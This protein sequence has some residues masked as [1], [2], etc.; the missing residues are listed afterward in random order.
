[1]S[2]SLVSAPLTGPGRADCARL[3]APSSSRRQ[4]RWPATR[5]SPWRS[6]GKG[7]GHSAPKKLAADLYLAL[8]IPVFGIQLQG[9]LDGHLQKA[10]AATSHSN[11]ARGRG[12]AS[13]TWR[14]LTR[15]RGIM[16]RPSLPYQLRN[17]FV[18]APTLEA[19]PT[20]ETAAKSPQFAV[21]RSH[22]RSIQSRTDSARAVCAQMET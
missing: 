7:T 21:S 11:L 3:L 1:M 9:H 2:S 5:A 12:L 6:T 16:A 4:S 15:A 8:W 19:G 22:T 20:S 13:S 14:Q 18:C 17:L 10:A